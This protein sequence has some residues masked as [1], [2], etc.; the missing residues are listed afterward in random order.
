[1]KKT[2][3][4]FIHISKG[5]GEQ[6][7]L[8]DLNLSVHE[9]EFLTLL[10]PSGCG[11]TTTLR[12]LGGFESP[13]KGQVIFD[14]QD[15]TPLPPNKRNLNTVFQKYALFSHM[16]V[17]ENIAFG[18]KI[19]GKSDAYIKDKIRYALK[20]VNLEGYENRLPDSLSG[21]QQQR[22]AIAR[23]IVNEPR[24]LL[25]DEPL[26]A[27]DLKLRQ[28][29]QYELIR[30]KNELGITF[31]YVTHDQEEAL[32]MSDTIVVMNQG[33]I[34]QMG[35]PEDIYNE[36]QNAFVADFIGESNIIEGIMI[37][38]RLVQIL[39]AK[40]DCVDTEFGQNKPVDVV[41]RPEDVDLVEPEKGTIT[42]VVTHLIFKGVHYEMEVQANGFE[43]LVHST[44]MFPVGQKV[45]IHVDPFDIQIMNKPES[46]DEEAI[47]VNE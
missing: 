32:T 23:A 35:S 9:N 17:S 38:D 27:L 43:W 40:F 47:G 10:G 14:G 5:F 3:V 18:L 34:Q 46:E 26:G 1:M 19:S 44:D 8:D 6:L 22:I 7:V 28:D 42:G 33:H 12:I 20:L 39:G 41:I 11:K 13:D 30:L 29:M 24:L 25:L 4:D 21:G 31:I 36:P 15:I 45:G 37:Q 16:S 2:L